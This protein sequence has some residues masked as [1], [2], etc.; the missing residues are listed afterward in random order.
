MPLHEL[1][2]KTTIDISPLPQSISYQQGILALGSC[3]AENVGEQLHRLRYHI[4]IN[5]FGTIFNPAS[6]ANS[7]DWILGDQ[8]FDEH[9]LFEHRGLWN[10]FYHYSLFSQ[11]NQQQTLDGINQRLSATR[12]QL[13]H[14]QWLILT[15]GTA[16]VFTLADRPDFVVSNCHQLP[17]NRFSRR[18]MEVYEIVGLLSRVLSRFKSQYPDLQVIVTVSPVRHIKDG[19]VENQLSKATLILAAHQLCQ[20]HNAFVHYF[21]AYE[22]LIDDLRDYRFYADDLVHPNNQAVTYITQCFDKFALNPNEHEVRNQVHRLQQA[23]EHR[24]LHPDSQAHQLFLQ[25]T[26]EKKAALQAQFPFLNWGAWET[27]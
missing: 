16:W 24:P 11:P 8:Y 2:W 18:R 12:A 13:P 15:L 3:F 23:L 22:L 7:L 19:L 14:T 20:Q 17:A 9:S 25:Q 5:P 4:D 10:S 27:R 21:P 26:Q 6:I 1:K